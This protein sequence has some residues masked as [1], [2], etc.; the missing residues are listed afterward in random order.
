M[1]L[2]LCQSA[3]LGDFQMKVD[4]KMLTTFPSPG[5][6]GVSIH[7]NANTKHAV[8]VHVYLYKQ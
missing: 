4:V 6:A 7:S 5:Y 1:V 8:H 2:K 3:G